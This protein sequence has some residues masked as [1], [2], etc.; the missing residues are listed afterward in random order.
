LLA[1]TIGLS[2]VVKSAINVTFF[3]VFSSNIIM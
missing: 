1:A 2:S 3:T